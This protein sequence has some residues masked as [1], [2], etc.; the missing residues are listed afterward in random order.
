MVQATVLDGLAFLGIAEL[1][2]VASDEYV[3]PGLLSVP[4]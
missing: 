4:Q 3:E 1:V 2:V